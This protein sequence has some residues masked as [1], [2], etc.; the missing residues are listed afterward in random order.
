M[1]YKDN[2]KKR[3]CPVDHINWN[4]LQKVVR[5]DNDQPSNT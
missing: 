3:N 4:K 1:R 2:F 5:A